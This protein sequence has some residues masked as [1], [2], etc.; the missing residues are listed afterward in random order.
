VVLCTWSHSPFEE[1]CAF[2]VK[3]LPKDTSNKII[4]SLICSSYQSVRERQRLCPLE[5]PPCRAL[6]QPSTRAHSHSL[7]SRGKSH[8]WTIFVH[9]IFPYI[10]S[11]LL[12]LRVKTPH[13]SQPKKLGYHLRFYASS[14]SASNLPWT[15]DLS[16]W[17]TASS[18]IWVTC[19]KLSSFCL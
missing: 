6:S 13:H 8:W 1:W 9:D 7:S 4:F 16:D 14:R 10:C 11:L 12:S 2:L 15:C 3:L 18:M 5:K 17:W 19:P